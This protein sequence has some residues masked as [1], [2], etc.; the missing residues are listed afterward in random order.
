MTRKRLAVIWL[1][2]VC[3][4]LA[5]QGWLWGVQRMA[6]DTDILALLPVQ[7]RDPV[8]QAAFGHMVDSAQQRV[9]VLVGAEQWD[10][11]ARAADAYQAVLARSPHLIRSSKLDG[12]TEADWLAGFR[13]HSLLLMTAADQHKLATAPADSWTGDALSRLY[14]PFGGPKLGAWRDD[15]FGLFGNWLQQRAQETPVRPRDGKLFVAGAGKQYVLL[16]LKLE[17]PALAMGTQPAVLAAL[18]AA[19]DAARAAVPQTEILTAGVILHAAHASSQAEREMS[20]IGIGSVAGIVLLM[21][22]SFR[23]LRPIALVV[24]SV[25]IGCLGALAVCTVLFDRVHLLTLV[26]GASLIGVAQDY[27]IYFLCKRLETGAEVDSSALLRRLLPALALTLL[28]A[29]LGYAGLALTPFPGL[30]Q[31]AVFS[32]TGLIFAWLTV[33]CWFPSM[34][35]AGSLNAGGLTR[36]YGAML[37]RWPLWRANRAGWLLAMVFALGAGFGIAQL[38][39]NDDIRLLQQPPKKLLDDQIK[40]GK[41]LDAP[42]PVQFFLVRGPNEVTVLRREEALKARLDPLAG[43]GHISGYQAISNWVPSHRLQQQR[44]EAVERHLLQA[45]G[46]LDKLAAKIE[47][48]PSWPDATRAHLRGA[49]QPLNV[50]AFMATPASEPWRHLWI[51]ATHGEVASIVAIRGLGRAGLSQVA[52]AADGM[53]GVQWVDKVGEI[54]AVLGR[55]RVYMGWVVLGAYL[56]VWCVLLPRYRGRAWRVIAPTAIASVTTLALLGYTG[57]PLQLF[58]ML[59]L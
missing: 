53:P 39:A 17:V 8:L 11:A 38:G 33:V 14:A 29:V 37:A 23:S 41:L 46:P 52:A 18:K 31:M 5:H 3:L 57:Q 48:E 25:G 32:A 59:A 44:R 10:D 19:A 47:E 28:A 1:L 20:T 40:L 12:Q 13:A 51:G 54:S 2:A 34:I 21:W 43:A 55:Y 16:P 27:G 58:H 56:L 4:L 6:P 35:A 42:T 26:F 36:R 9:V 24:L 15:P 50:A 45:G 30:R 49:A 22:L 7:E